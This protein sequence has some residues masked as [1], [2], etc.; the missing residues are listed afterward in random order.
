M[1]FCPNCNNIFDITSSNTQSGPLSGGYDYKDYINKVLKK[2]PIGAEIKDITL[3]DLTKSDSFNKLDADEKSYVYNKTAELLKTDN[4]WKNKKI[5]M[6]DNAEFICN[7]CGTRKKIKEK[8]LIFSRASSDV[9][10]GYVANDFSIMQHSDILP[11]TRKY[12]CPN[13][14]CESQKNFEAREAVFF[15]LNNSF[16]VK[17]LCLSCK[18]VFD[19]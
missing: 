14:A 2:R 11:R 1:F 17:Y 16:R 10:Q 6:K 4:E 5:E 18:T 3:N 19:S 8:T 9:A 13:D 12:V 7:N 15:R